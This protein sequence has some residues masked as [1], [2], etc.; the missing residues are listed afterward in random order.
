[1][2]PPASLAAASKRFASGIKSASYNDLPTL[3]PVAAIKVF[4]IP[5]PTMSWSTL[6]DKASSTV[7]LVD[8]LEPPTIASIGRA[9]LCNAL[10]SASNSPASKGPAQATG[11]NLPAPWVDAW[12]R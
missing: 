4:A 10:P 5:P 12:A 6:F 7:S 1:M 8:T 2:F 3:L 9:G 11:A